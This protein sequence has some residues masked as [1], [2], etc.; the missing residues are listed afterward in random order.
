MASSP[1]PCS[2]GRIVCERRRAVFPAASIGFSRGFCSHRMAYLLNSLT[3]KKEVDCVVIRDTIDKVLV[4]RFGRETDAIYLQL[5]DIL[6]KSVREVSR[7]AAVALVDIDSEDVQLLTFLVA[8][9]CGRSTESV[10]SYIFHYAMDLSYQ[11]VDSLIWLGIRDLINDVQKKKLK[12]RPVTYLS[13]SQGY[14]S[15]VPYGYIWSPHLVPKPKDWGPKIDVVGF[16]FLDLASNY[17][18]PQELVD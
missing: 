7:F 6:A 10:A 2:G 5:D 9:S 12:L 11:I 14:D 3:K 4:L 17:E 13:G 18:S 1:P 16:Y 8:Y 15:D